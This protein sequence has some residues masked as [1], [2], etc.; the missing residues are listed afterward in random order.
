MFVIGLI[1]FFIAVWILS[2]RQGVLSEIRG[3]KSVETSTI[4][5]LLDIGNS[6]KKEL[7]SV[8]A[9]QEQVK[10]K[11]TIHSNKPITAE[12]SKRPCVYARTQV[13]EKYEETYSEEGKRKT[14]HG[15]TTLTDNTLQINFELEDSSRQISINPNGAEIEPKQV[16]NRQE[17]NNNPSSQESNGKRILAYQ[18]NEWILPLDEMVYVLGEIRDSEGELVIQKPLDNQS[19]FLITHQSEEQLLQE[20]QSKARKHNV[21]LI[22][23]TL[24]IIGIL[25][26]LFDQNQSVVHDIRFMKTTRTYTVDEL[27]KLPTVGRFKEQVEV[28]GT[29]ESKNPIIAE[30]SKRPSVY[31]RTQ[32]IEKYE[33]TYSDDGETKTRQDSTTLA[34]NTL[35]IN[36]QLEDGTG[37]I[38]VNPNGAEIEAKQVV[39]HYK[40]NENPSTQ[41]S[42]DKRILGYQSNEW[43]L[44]LEQKIFVL[45]EIRDTEGELVIQKPLDNQSPFLITYKSKEQLLQEKQS[46]S[47][48]QKI[49]IAVL[50]VCVICI[51]VGL[52]L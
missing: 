12:L 23:V 42:K 10:V 8:G 49:R 25:V 14:R 37:Q 22:F 28:Y 31:A 51:F 40:L 44:P 29:I 24:T 50:L 47:R 13:L 19:Q 34:D 9:F 52:G 7:G 38:Q 15:S 3:I 36:F 26:G 1:L 16:V 32:L 20:K 18:Y 43:I 27:Q 6:I 48:N 33:E 41:N 46:Q 21:R 4:E 11:G 30:L 45:G 5:E 17:L 39:N 2:Q 35:Q